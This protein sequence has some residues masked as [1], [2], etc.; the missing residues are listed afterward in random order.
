[1]R[2][3]ADGSLKWHFRHFQRGDS[4][5]KATTLSQKTIQHRISKDASGQI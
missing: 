3:L 4:K 1:M 2:E 5:I